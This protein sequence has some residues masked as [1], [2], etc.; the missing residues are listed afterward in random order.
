M[1]SN[2]KL[3]RG[4]WSATIGDDVLSCLDR[5]IEIS[6]A[7]VLNARVAEQYW[8]LW[9]ALNKRLEPNRPL[10][11]A[12]EWAAPAGFGVLRR[13]LG[14]SAILAALRVSDNPSSTSLSACVLAGLLHNENV[15]KVLTSETWFTR[16][17]LTS[18]HLI[19]Q[20]EVGFQPKRINWFV[21]RVPAAWGPREFPPDN[22][23][24]RRARISLKAFRDKRIAHTDSNFAEAAGPTI[25]DI[26]AAVRLTKQVALHASLIFLG[27][28]SGAHSKLDE[29]AADMDPL[30]SYLE[31]GMV[32]AHDEHELALRGLKR[33]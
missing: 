26:R 32:A 29:T 21:D 14:E 15:T 2:S 9:E 22:D 5:G 4:S 3:Q 1:T 11:K 13:S 30:W 7:L 18:D 31:R 10:R 6:N 12:A 8:A 17:G 25:D 33:K 27:S 23:E 28:T 19:V 24:L 20:S 16:K